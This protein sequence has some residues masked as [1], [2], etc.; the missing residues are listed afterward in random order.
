MITIGRPSGYQLRKLQCK[1]RMLPMAICMCA[2]RDLSLEV[3]RAVLTQVASIHN[4]F[5]RIHY[6][7][8]VQLAMEV[9][10]EG[11]H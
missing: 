11:I 6:S 1:A 3:I 10:N 7:L 5:N 8:K 9:V 4:S 2:S